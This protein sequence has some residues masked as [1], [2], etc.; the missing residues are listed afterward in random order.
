MSFVLEINREHPE[1]NNLPCTS[2]T[3]KCSTFQEFENA[4]SDAILWQDEL[5]E[6]P[7]DLRTINS[8]IQSAVKCAV[9]LAE[10]LADNIDCA[11]CHQKNWD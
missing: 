10:T 3:N 9:S 11:E 6:L 5:R 1:D 8:D 4:V 2:C 7:E